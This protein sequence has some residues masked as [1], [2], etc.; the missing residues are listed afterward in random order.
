MKATIDDV[1]REA[2]VSTATVSRVVNN[3]YPVAKA[4]REK[5]ERAIEKLNFT[6]NA[7][8]KGLML[9]KSNTIGVIIPSVMNPY[10]LQIVEEIERIAKA[11]G[12]M[13]LL[14]AAKTP[15]EE[16]E[17]LQNLINRTV[18]GVI[19]VDG[20]TQNRTNH[21]FEKIGKKLPLVL[22]NGYNQGIK[23]NFIITDQETGARDAL[24]Y[25]YDLGHRRIG[26]VSS[27]EEE[28][29]D[30]SYKLK[31]NVYRQFLQEKGLAFNEN[32][33]LLFPKDMDDDIQDVENAKALLKK[34]FDQNG[35]V[36][37]A[38][39]A[40]ND[41]MGFAIISAANELGY[42]VPEDLSI[43]GFDNSLYS[44]IASP[45]LTTVDINT[46]KLGASSA[47][48]LIDIIENGRKGYEKITLSTQLVVRKSCKEKA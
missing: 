26:F 23:C 10:F 24:D 40:N 29:Y 42:K 4:T 8:A 2:G 31:E 45:P 21:Y 3:N 25:L 48:M 9:R 1:A 28:P 39:F 18:D 13:V 46:G 27:V 32:D 44:R 43:V 20:T 30:Y 38:Y 12:Y 5:V 7:M 6:P 33:M 17:Y 34:R 11:K 22:I 37:T 15:E 36:P 47:D 41:V 16:Q 19:V 35:S 14:C